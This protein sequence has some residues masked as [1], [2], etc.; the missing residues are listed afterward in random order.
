LYNEIAAFC[1]RYNIAIRTSVDSTFGPFNPASEASGLNAIREE[2]LPY[3]SWYAIADLD[4]FHYFRGKSLLEIAQQAESRHCDAVHG[5]FFDRI[6]ADGTFPK[7]DGTL[8]DTFP[9]ACDLTRCFGGCCQKI[10][11]ARNHVKISSGHHRAK[12]K[13]W[14]DGAQVHHFKW[15]HGIQDVIKDRHQRFKQQGLRWAARELPLTE[16]LIAKRINLQDPRLH[17]RKAGKLWV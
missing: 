12:G 17:L 7:I 11:L 6:A 9:L 8:D 10:V 1:S 13:I 15:H 4:E 2:F 16:K 3:N 14:R 5:V